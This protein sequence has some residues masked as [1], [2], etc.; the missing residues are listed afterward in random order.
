[1]GF[2]CLHCFDRF[3]GRKE[4]PSGD[5]LRVEISSFDMSTD[6]EGRDNAKSMTVFNVTDFSEESWS[7]S[8]WTGRLELW[9]YPTSRNSLGGEV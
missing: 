7:I 2:P 8:H 5:D 6:L 3:V 4:N 9:R 1:M